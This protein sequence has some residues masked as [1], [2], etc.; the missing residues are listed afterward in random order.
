MSRVFLLAFT[1]A[2]A[3]IPMA[4]GS[5]SHPMA[6]APRSSIAGVRASARPGH[7]SVTISLTASTRRVLYGH[8]VTVSGR[9]STRAAGAHV[10][11]VARTYG[12]ASATLGVTTVTQPG[13]R[14]SFRAWPMIQ[15]SYTARFRA[16]TSPS[17]VV[18]VEPRRSVKVLA[19]GAIVTHVASPRRLTR[20]LVQLQRRNATGTWS[21]I[22]RKRLDRRSSIVFPAPSGREWKRSASQ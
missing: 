22:A 11:V 13:G 5:L 10:M 2:I 6:G 16:A 19:G 9:V 8:S 7:A 21:T 1:A 17:V 20:R 12:A 4:A 15:T 18:G 14:W 3:P